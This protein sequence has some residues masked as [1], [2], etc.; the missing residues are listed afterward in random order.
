M[1]I[2]EKVQKFKDAVLEKEEPGF[3]DDDLAIM[4]RALEA[5]NDYVSKVDSMEQQMQLARFH[6][7][8]E[9]WRELVERLDRN[10][11]VAHDAMMVDINVV[12]RL[13]AMFGI[14]PFFAPK[15]E[16]DRLEYAAFA[17]EV[18]DTY[19]AKGQANAKRS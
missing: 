12:N 17:K 3:I 11:R 8:G 13:C 16:N 19:F 7:E 9:E 15:D 10:R 4:K 18:V 1:A 5:C 14:E 2:Y 6:L